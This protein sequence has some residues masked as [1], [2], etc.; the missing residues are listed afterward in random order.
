VVCNYKKTFLKDLAE[1]PAK[2][3]KSIEELVFGEI[4]ASEAIPDAVDIKR[5]QGHAHY[6]R[7][8]VGD[9]RIGCEVRERNK[10]VFYR[11]KH[12]KDIYRVFP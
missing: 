3:R 10:V 8:R 6:F 4:P 12:R 2:H 7:I 11:V 9:Y 5:I 1:L